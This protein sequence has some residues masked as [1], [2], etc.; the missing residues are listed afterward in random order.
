MARSMKTVENLIKVLSKL[1]G[2]GPKSAR[3]FA[4]YLIKHPKEVMMPLSDVLMEV[5][6]SIV[7]CEHCGNIDLSSPCNIC[8]DEKRDRST[9]CVV[10]DINDLWAMNRDSFFNGLYHVLGG[11]LSVI[12][13]QVPESLNIQS[14]CKRIEE[15]NIQEVIIATNSTIEGQTTAHYIYDMLSKYNIKIT[16]LAHGIPVGAEL[17]YMDDGTLSLAM[18]LRQ[19]F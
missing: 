11:V 1:P 9:I 15:N 16:R 12:E 7:K 8:I 2:V 6:Q 3:R 5:A 10:E 4:L 17:D 14:L 18:K 19:N 13:G